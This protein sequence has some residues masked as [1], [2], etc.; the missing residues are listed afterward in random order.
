MQANKALPICI[1]DGFFF[2][3][4]LLFHFFG[5]LLLLFLLFLLFLLLFGRGLHLLLLHKGGIRT[6][7]FEIVIRVLFCLL[8]HLFHLFLLILFAVNNS[9]GLDAKDPLNR[10]EKEIPLRSFFTLS[11]GICSPLA[12]I[13]EVLDI[14]TQ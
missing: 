2:L 9:V 3:L 5:F 1:C 14:L 12:T 8:D 10:V 11:R 6:T 4:L 13:I 7:H